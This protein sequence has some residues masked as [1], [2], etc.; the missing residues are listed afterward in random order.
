MRVPEVPPLFGQEVATQPSVNHFATFPVNSSRLGRSKLWR[1]ALFWLGFML[2]IWF[3]ADLIHNLH[4][5]CLKMALADFQQVQQAKMSFKFPNS[6]STPMPEL[7]NPTTPIA[8]FRLLERNEGRIAYEMRHQ[9]SAHFPARSQL[10]A[11]ESGLYE[12]I[13]LPTVPFASKTEGRFHLALSSRDL[14][15]GGENKMADHR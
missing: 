2:L 14:R 9:K 5:F 7:K 3:T 12:Y 10:C 15:S 11:F 1:M 13:A 4:V 6:S 8:I